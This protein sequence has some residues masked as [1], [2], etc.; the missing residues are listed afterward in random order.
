MKRLKSVVMVATAIVAMGS[1]GNK[2]AQAPVSEEPDTTVVVTINRDSMVYG[3]CGDG[4]AMNTLQLITDIGDTLTLSIAEANDKGKCLGGFQSG[5]RM[6]VMLKNKTVASMVIN[7]SALLGDWV[8]PNPLD[9]S[10]EMGIRIKEGGIAESIEQ[11]SLIYRSWK[12]FNGKLEIVAIREG[13]GDVE[14]TNL[15]DIVSIGSDSLVYKDA[16]DTFEYSRYKPQERKD[17]VEF[18]E[19]SIDDFRM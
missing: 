16:E 18:E 4:S 14:E 9:G 11:P 12:L 5:D 17:I 6:A 3:I 15:Y 1:C 7:Q 2:S 13:G 19:T 10:S 8:M